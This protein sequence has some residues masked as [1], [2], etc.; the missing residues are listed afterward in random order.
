MRVTTRAFIGDAPGDLLAFAGAGDV[1]AG[2]TVFVSANERTEADKIVGVFA[3]GTA[4]IAAGTAVTVADKITE[5]FIGNGAK[6]TGDGN[7]DGLTVRTGGLTTGVDLGAATFDPSSPSGE[8]IEVTD[9]GVGS[10]D[11]STLGAQ[12]EIG[13]PQLEPINADQ[14][15][16]NSDDVDNDSLNGQRTVAPATLPSFRGVAVSATNVDDIEVF[17]VSLGFGTVGIAISAPVNVIDT[18]TH[19]YIGD[20]AQVNAD[21]SSA[22]AAQSVLVGAGND[23]HHISVAGSIAAGTVGVSPAA[24]ISVLTFVTKAEIRSGATVNARNDIFVTAASTEDMLMIGFGLAAGTVGVGGAVTVLA[25]DSMT[26]A[27]VGVGSDLTAGDTVLVQANDETSVLTVSGA[28]AAGLVGVGGSV[29][30]ITID[31]LTTASMDGDVDARGNGAGVPDVMNGVITGDGDAFGRATVRGLIV[32]AESSE[33]VFHLALAG[34]FGYVGVSGAVLVTLVDSDTT[35]LIGG[36]ADVN[37]TGGNAGAGG[38]QSVFVNAANE[39]RVTT[40]AI[41]A[42]GGLVGLAGAVDF[43]SV[44]NDQA[45][46]ILGGAAITASK[47]VEVNALAIVEFDGFTFS[48]AGGLVGLSAAVSVWSIGSALE[49]SYEDNDGNSARA[50]ENEDGDKTADDD[51]AQQT[52]TVTGEVTGGLQKFGDNPGSDQSSMRTASITGTAASRLAADGPT[53]SSLNALINSTVT[54]M[55]TEA[56]VESGTSGD[57]TRIDAGEDVEVRAEVDVEID[58]ITGGFAG[59]LVGLGAGV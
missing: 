13:V 27:L 57:P 10:T 6:V 8:G 47:D 54:P 24:D 34:G 26:S 33:D 20:D 18:T 40:F 16:G 38:L 22:G 31:K 39:V 4:G 50:G 3:A 48:G 42:A 28:I 52:E 30:V 46:K 51:A 14:D 7:T 35:A 19:A 5:A 37:Q 9:S 45:A 25:V 32:Q 1:H 17:T 11:A 56:V 2:G 55:G 36:S 53:R 12:G 15:D 44:K 43:G 23:F 41:G 59:G 21:T 29:G 49:S 58:V